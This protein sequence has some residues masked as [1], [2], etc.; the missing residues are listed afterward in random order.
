M[1]DPF[2]P[3]SRYLGT[4]SH[5]K[6]VLV[7]AMDEAPTPNFE[8]LLL[9]TTKVSS[10]KFLVSCVS[11]YAW[12]TCDP[13]LSVPMSY[14]LRSGKEFRK[15]LA[16]LHHWSP[17][18]IIKTHAHASGGVSTGPP[19]VA[20]TSGSSPL[21]VIYGMNRGLRTMCTS[22]A[23]QKVSCQR[24]LSCPPPPSSPTEFTSTWSK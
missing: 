16:L 1:P 2:G 13:S 20:W 5:D 10:V 6:R 24:A 17:Q 3:R 11:G 14:F 22:T 7:V 8:L 15:P 23:L 19:L 12:H 21:D 18:L 9:G 4:L